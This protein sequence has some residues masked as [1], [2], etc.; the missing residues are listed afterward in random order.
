M[1]PETR[2][3]AGVAFRHPPCKGCTER[4]PSCHG[5]CEKYKEWRAAYENHRDVVIADKA[6]HIGTTYQILRSAKIQDDYIRRY[7]IY[8]KKT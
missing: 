8:G 3:L 6:K 2:R 1:T 5:A 4:R 7:R